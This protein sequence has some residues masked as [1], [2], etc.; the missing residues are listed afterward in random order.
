M[1]LS[2]KKGKD[3]SKKEVALQSENGSQYVK[4]RSDSRH[5]LTLSQNLKGERCSYYGNVYIAELDKILD[6]PN[7]CKD[8]SGVRTDQNFLISTNVIRYQTY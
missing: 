1:L 8:L 6:A 7:L 4:S 3:I 2:D 5:K